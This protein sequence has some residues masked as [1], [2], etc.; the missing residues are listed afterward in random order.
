MRLITGP[1]PLPEPGE[2]ATGGETENPVTL[3]ITLSGSLSS[4]PSFTINSNS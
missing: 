1:G 4:L 2:R 3:I